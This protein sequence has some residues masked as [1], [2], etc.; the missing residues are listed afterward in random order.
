MRRFLLRIT[1]L[2]CL[3]LQA[4][5]GWGHCADRALLVGIDR[6]ADPR[7]PETPGCV[8]DAKGVAR[9]LQDE[10]GVAVDDIRV[11]C[12]DQATAAAV[13]T[14][15][16][17]WLVAG[18][19]PGDRVFFLYSGHGSQLPDD[20][21]DD[22]KDGKDETLALYDVNPE[23]GANEIRDDVFAE[24]IAR[25]SGRRA[26]LVFDSCHSG[27]ISRGLPRLSGY[28]RGGGVRWLPSPDQLF[29]SQ[30]AATRSAGGA[31]AYVA[32]AAPSRSRD[33][34]ESDFIN[35]AELGRLSGV[36]IISAAAD[37]QQAF[38]LE[39][40]R[41]YRGALSL[42]L[43]E[44]LRVRQ[45]TFAELR[46]EVAKTIAG[47]QRS[48]RLEGNQTPQFEAISTI[49][50]DDAPLF[51]SWQE[52]AA[53]SLVNPLS[54]IQ[55]TL[56]TVGGRTFYNFGDKASYRV[57]VDTAGYLYLLV[58]SQGNVATCIFPSSLDLDNRVPAGDV[59][60][61][62]NQAHEFTVQEPAGQDVVVALLSRERLNLGEEQKYTWQ[63]VFARLGLNRLQEAVAES[64]RRASQSRG[65]G[66]KK[67]AFVLPD[68]DWQA[69]SIVVEARP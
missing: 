24:L 67:T 1:I 4:A 26:V 51:G 29:N 21:G 38:P 59:E 63:E 7:V 39:S 47:W 6:Y 57:R 17:Q 33:L 50:L 68:T 8:A 45:R 14:A 11:L 54:S 34:H 16:R 40:E 15:F 37:W 69:A 44:S 43:E 22:V 65:L 42:A 55:I 12:N 13:E 46:Q 52:A 18:T 30:A 41:G 56:S 2:A 19:G 49:P 23:T 36:V 3:A 35:G 64:A 28:P 58:F 32:T 53:V 9:L 10:Y 27:T 5:G 25:L 66:V 61:P 31:D 48:G 62:R 60:L 20:D